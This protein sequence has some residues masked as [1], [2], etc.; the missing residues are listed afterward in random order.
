MRLRIRG[1]SGQSSLSLSGEATVADL[2]RHIVD[3][4]SISNFDLNYGYPPKP[5]VLDD[6]D[7]ASKLIDLP[8]K[9]DGE[10]LLVSNKQTG[11]TASIS[12][13]D[14]KLQNRQVLQDPQSSI[15]NTFAENTPKTSSTGSFSFSGV[16]EAPPPG[17][18]ST[19]PLQARNSSAPLSLQRKPNPTVDDPPE[20]TLPSHSAKIL[21]RIMPDDNSCLFRAFGSAFFGIMD[22]MTEL[23]AIIASHIYENKDEYSE[24]VL[25]KPPDDYCRWI[26]TEDAWGGAIELNVL[27]RQFGIEICSIDVQTLR[28]DRF[29]E[30]MEKRCILVYSGIHYDTIALSQ[31][32]PY[33]MDGYAQPEEDV[34]IFDAGDE[35]ILEAAL[36]LC[37]ELKKRHYYTDT[38][39][40]QVKCNICGKIFVGE[41]GATEHASKTGHYDFG[42]A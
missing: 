17:M 33:S 42:E 32:D 34:K 3:D 36:Q 21:L 30:G 35:R 41:K 20:V 12:Y 29:N 10:Q 18:L 26:Q 1:P 25:E 37:G 11:T 7:K 24:V 14:Q 9:L 15:R 22:N 31:S 16:G 8:I 19:P 23:R 13:P 4:T 6:F 28:V 5:L 27:S 39:G 38:A 2:Q 40:F